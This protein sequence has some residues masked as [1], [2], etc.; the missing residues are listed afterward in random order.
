MLVR[1]AFLRKTTLSI[2]KPNHKYA[3]AFFSEI[4]KWNIT[5]DA[6]QVTTK[7]PAVGIKSTLDGLGHDDERRLVV[8]ELKTTQYTVDQHKQRYDAPCQNQPRLTNGLLNTERTRHNL[9]CGFGVIA[10]SKSAFETGRMGLVVVVCADG[11]MSYRVPTNY[12]ILDLFGGNPGLCGPISKLPT[13]APQFI[14]WPQDDA[15]LHRVLIQAGLA[16]IIQRGK[17]SY[18]ASEDG[19]IGAILGIVH[20][21][22]KHTG[23]TKEKRQLKSLGEAAK[24]RR[25]KRNCPARLL[26][27]F[28]ACTGAGWQVW[29]AGRTPSSC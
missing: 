5:L 21:H 27:L 26:T 25:Q 22:A 8:L 4:R 20:F 15:S 16:K 23:S 10:A 14:R 7:V 18:V 3:I 1:K 6:V 24:H 19:N 29:Q 9:Q 2:N 12:Y 17:V 13:R 11:V 28:A